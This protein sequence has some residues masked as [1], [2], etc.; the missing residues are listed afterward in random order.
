[1]KKLIEKKYHDMDTFAGGVFG[2]DKKIIKIYNLAMKNE[3]E[4]EV[5]NARRILLKKGYYLC[6]RT[7]ILW[8]KDNVPE[9]IKE[10]KDYKI[11]F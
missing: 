5:L 2:L 1:M 8:Y 4:N 11:L 3:N 6:K 9:F 10:N 7:G